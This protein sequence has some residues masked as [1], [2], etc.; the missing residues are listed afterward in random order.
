MPNPPHILLYEPRS[1]GH[2]PIFLAYFASAFVQIGYRVTVCTDSK[3]LRW[4]HISQNVDKTY[5]SKIESFPLPPSAEKKQHLKALCTLNAEIN[6]DEIFLCSLDEI[7]S[8]L[9]R[10][11][12]LGLLPAL[13]LSGKI[14]GL[15]IRPR[16]LTQSRSLGLA[17]KRHGVHKLNKKRF[18]K[19]IFVLDER[20]TENAREYTSNIPIHWLPD[21]AP[22]YE[23]LS[24]EEAREKL[25]LPQNA[26]IPLI[27]G[28]GHK[29]KGIGLAIDAINKLSDPKVFL[30]CAGKQDPKGAWLQSLETLCRN[31]Q[32]SLINAFIPEDTLRDCLA[33][34]DVVLLP[35]MSHFGSSNNLA[36]AAHAER[37]V[38]SSDYDLVGQRVKKHGLGLTFKN[39]NP[40]SLMQALSESILR[41]QKGLTPDDKLALKQ[42]AAMH[43][44]DAFN[45]HLSQ[46]D[47]S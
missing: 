2:H 3:N 1:E 8:S 17:L 43:S 13:S 30:L 36:L 34:C 28:Q 32:A 22:A 12:A 9:W 33:A 39:E 19:R 11:A 31:R 21:P 40:E 5:L 37:P 41:H 44:L 26:F 23:Y 6:P 16:V 25:S 47:P 38:I 7:A 29:R 4:T 27:F 35:Y 46:A 18:F 15:Y 45:R 20:I 24:R 10:K 14:S 42:Y